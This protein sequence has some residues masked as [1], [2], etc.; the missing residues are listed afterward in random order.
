MRLL[1]RS[2]RL[3]ALVTRV[4]IAALVLPTLSRAQSAPV[5]STTDLV[6]TK[7]HADT[8]ARLFKQKLYEPA[9][10]EY[11]AAYKFS[12]RPADL[13]RVAECQREL[14]DAGAALDTYGELAA[15]PGTRLSDRE[16]KA[17]TKIIADLSTQTGAI[18][19][20]VAPPGVT[21]SVGARVLGVTP[22]A[23][24]FNV[25]AGTHLVRLTKDE[26]EP[27]ERDVTVVAGQ[28]VTLTALMQ[29]KQT[30]GFLRVREKAQRPVSV[31]V[32]GKDVGPAP[33]EGFVPPGEHQVELK[34]QGF[35]SAVQSVQ[36]NVKQQVTVDGDAQA[37]TGKI[38]VA[39]TPASAAILIDGKE[40]A[41]GTWDGEIGAGPHVLSV[42]ARGYETYERKLEIMAGQSS[43]ESMTLQ[44]KG[45]DAAELARLAQLKL[46]AEEDAYHGIYGQF[47]LMPLY[48][49]LT[50]P[51]PP[52]TGGA[53]CDSP[54]LPL[55]GGAV[56]RVGYGLGLLG[57]EL[58]GGFVANSHEATVNFP[59][60]ITA[61]TPESAFPHQETYRYTALG[62]FG[63]IGP[64]LTSHGHVVRVTFGIDGGVSVRSWR[65][66]KTLSGGLSA[67]QQFADTQ[68]APAGIADLG[69][70]FGSTP[71]VRFFI[72]ITAMLEYAA[73]PLQA[74]PQTIGV[75]PST[76]GAAPF[77]VTSPTY[78]VSPQTQIYVGPT[79]GLNF[80]H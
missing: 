67:T 36:V 69:V 46:D 39:A 1:R 5:A 44:V 12:H 30:Q 77:N 71:G 25:N 78:D 54:G 20:T 65:L 59:S 38:K 43:Q 70:T 35:A 73:S 19:V 58:A 16:K 2:P 7:R 37:T 4:A 42:E 61:S 21:V 29:G 23:K 53:L 26:L 55:A 15:L 45:P 31:L 27:W 62:G 75:T 34:G 64:R 52:C 32:D 3:S 56:A 9:L 17:F 14:H 63:G 68:V 47:A 74:P 50:R 11:E 49:A 66:D 76:P 48:P 18:D 13:Q 72:G 24:P 41:K 60:P 28:K 22:L 8:G 57:I 51:A 6:E 10:V 40:V 80:G 79:I 33:W